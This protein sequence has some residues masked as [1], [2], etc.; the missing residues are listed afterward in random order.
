MSLLKFSENW[1][2]KTRLSL[3]AV[4]SL[5]LGTVPSSLLLVQYGEQLGI[6]AAE[7]H[8]LPANRAWQAALVALQGQRAL[9]AEAL[10]TKPDSKPQAV[11]AAD[12]ATR[13]LRAL[14]EVLS[15]DGLDA[16]LAAQQRER[17]AKLLAQQT[18]LAKALA[19]G[20]AGRAA[21]DGR[22]AQPRRSGLRRHC[23][24]QCRGRPAAGP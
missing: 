3:V 23:R 5:V 16:T 11:A 22:P 7:Q 2:L 12:Q 24:A 18:E 8:A 20:A 17:V 6:V 1:S 10:S 19:Q 14:D 13:A 15:K 4:L 21:T 9:G